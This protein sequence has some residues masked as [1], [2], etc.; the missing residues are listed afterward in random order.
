MAEPASADD[1]PVARIGGDP[2]WLSD[3]DDQINRLDPAAQ[4]NF[5][6]PEAKREF[7]HQYVGA[8]LLYRAAMR[9]NYLSDPD[10]Q[11]AQEQLT[12]QLLVNRYLVDKVM[13]NVAADSV[14][15]MNFYKANRDSR[16]DGAPFDSVASQ[17][18]MD[19]HN[20][21]AQSAYQ[22]YIAKLAKQERVEFL[23]P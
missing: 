12:R 20:Q 5:I 13:P 23:D 15:V 14:D 9:E 16:Y 19:Y 10:I 6:T 3:V 11:K 4:K 7:A 21:K 22:D 17:V 1:V 2:V 8:E 18:F